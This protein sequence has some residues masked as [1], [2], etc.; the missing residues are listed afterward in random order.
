VKANGT[1]ELNQSIEAFCNF[2][3]KL[4]S[5][6]LEEQDWGPK[7]VLAHLVFHHELYVKLVEADVFKLPLVPLEGKYREINSRAV[8]ANRGCSVDQLVERLRLANRRLVELYEAYDPTRIAVQI[9]AGVIVR[10]LAELVPGVEAH[11]RNHLEMLRKN[12]RSD[13]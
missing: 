5:N 7:E 11:I 6:Y 12:H 1:K 3:E 2:I 10:S 13:K 9:K 4:P 8:A